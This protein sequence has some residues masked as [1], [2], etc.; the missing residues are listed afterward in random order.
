MS[1]EQLNTDIAL[2][3]LIAINMNN[4]ILAGCS[5]LGASTKR[6]LMD[7]INESISKVNELVE[8]S[9]KLDDAGL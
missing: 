2:N 9:I 7:K 4:V 6:G 3:T 5:D 8:K 1:R